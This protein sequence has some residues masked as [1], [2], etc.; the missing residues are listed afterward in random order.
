MRALVSVSDKNHLDS[1]I[2][3]FKKHSIDVISSGGTAKYLRDK[4]MDVTDVSKVTGNPEAFGGRMKT[5]SFDISSALLF[6]RDHEEDLTQ[7]KVLGI[8]AI[9]LVICNLYPFAEVKK[10]K[11]TW[12]DLVENIDIGGPSMV[13]AAAKNYKDVWILT[14]PSQYDRF[15]THYESND[16]S[17]K[18]QARFELAKDAFCHTASY[19]SLIASTFCEQN[20]EAA[21]FIHIDKET[22]KEVR[23]GENPHQ[24]GFVSGMTG[25]AGAIPLQGKE[26]SYNNLLDSD[27]AYRSMCDLN[28]LGKKYAITVIKHSNPCGQAI[29][30]NG[31]ET[32]KAAWAGDPI[33]AFGS[34]I[35][36][37]N[38]LDGEMA[39][40]LSERFVEVIMAPSF[41]EEAL[42]VLA[43][44][45]NLR[46]LKLDKLTY[47]QSDYMVR[48][49]DG[50]FLLQEEDCRKEDAIRNVTDDAKS[51]QTFSDTLIK[52]GILACKHLKSNA[53]CLVKKSDV[54]YELIGAGMGNPNRLIST[55]QAF[56]KARENGHTNFEDVVLVSD[57]FFPFRD[58]VDLAAKNGIKGIVQP[59]GSIRDEEVIAACN[60][61]NIAMYFTGMRHF[62]H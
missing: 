36:V 11:G 17:L 7:A 31:L 44:R 9:D 8:E 16:E 38:E 22:A 20:K 45:K 39:S 46:V 10:N 48:T 62:R 52:F 55:E 26:L 40:F 6:R 53:I 32:L 56:D 27:A 15:V 23:Y 19:D 51:S 35:A 50:G 59:G 2:P 37:S 4:D 33:S 14:N 28:D 41:S 12:E 42:D 49:I 3:F 47:S 5:L 43:K 18:L 21:P 61:N 30:D 60:E 57:A 25:I 34:I 13:R 24:K 54:G 58:N 1:L 29:G